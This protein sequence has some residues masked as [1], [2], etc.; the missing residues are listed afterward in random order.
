[1]TLIMKDDEKRVIRET[2]ADHAVVDGACPHCK[3]TPLKV[4]GHG[5]RISSDDRAYEADG[6]CVACVVFVGVIRAETNTL[7]GLR[8]DEAV[9]RLGVRIY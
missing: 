6:S 7:F 2:H 4:A 1:M 5:R 3:A 8:E 9:S